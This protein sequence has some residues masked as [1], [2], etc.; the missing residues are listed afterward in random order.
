MIREWNGH[1]PRIDP[2]AYVHETAEVIGKVVLGKNASVWPNAVLRGDIEEIVIG[3]ETNIQDNTV[4][5]T[6]YGSPTILGKGISVGHSVILHGCTIKDNCLIGMGSIILD[7]V[8]VETE[9]L[10]GAGALVSPGKT[11]PRG[12]L[13][14]GVP[15][16]VKRALEPD[17]IEHFKNNAKDYLR[18]AETHRKTSRK[19]T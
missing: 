10:I 12:S 13:A 2:T 9:C 8:T 14:V 11:I 16:Q 6:D 19:L 17:E 15:A 18:L 4:I 3:E 5:H 7:G 1:R